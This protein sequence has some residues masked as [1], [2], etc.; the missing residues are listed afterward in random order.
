MG[1]TMLEKLFFSLMQFS[2][3]LKEVGMEQVMEVFPRVVDRFS[4]LFYVDHMAAV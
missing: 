1:S 4:P 3:L 2:G